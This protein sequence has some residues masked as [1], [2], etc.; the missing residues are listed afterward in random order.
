MFWANAIQ[1]AQISLCRLIAIFYF[2]FWCTDGRIMVKLFTI[3]FQGLWNCNNYYSKN[4]KK[5]PQI[6][7]AECH[8][9]EVCEILSVHVFFF[10]PTGLYHFLGGSKLATGNLP[11]SYL[12]VVLVSIKLLRHP[13]PPRSTHT[14]IPAIIKQLIPAQNK[15]PDNPSPPS[16]S[17]AINKVAPPKSKT[18]KIVIRNCCTRGVSGLHTL[19]LQH[20]CNCV[21]RSIV[22]H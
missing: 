17:D 8:C 4:E 11:A 14:I 6:I 10:L 1:I 22:L 13:W 2:W 16:P 5:R 7:I 12:V 9:F 21:H 3:V 15:S 20:L 19:I 18:K